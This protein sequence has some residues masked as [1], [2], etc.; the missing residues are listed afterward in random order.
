MTTLQSEITSFYAS[1]SKQAKEWVD[2]NQKEKVLAYCLKER[3]WKD[4]MARERFVPVD[5]SS[6]K[7][8]A[9]KIRMLLQS[10][11]INNTCEIVPNFDKWHDKM[12]CNTD[13]GM[14]YGVWQKFINIAFKNFYCVYNISDKK[15]FSEFADIWNDC[16]FTLDSYTL[17][18]YDELPIDAKTVCL[19][20]VNWNNISRDTYLA[21][22]CDVKT[23]IQKE[24]GMSPFDYEFIIWPEIIERNKK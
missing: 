21:I 24:K 4:A 15:M 9:E 18:W 17:Q 19:K 6:I 7:R 8:N 16:H 3:A 23:Y 11:I 2:N 14:R 20:G 5:K 22:Q 12:C 10:E 1:F 13:L